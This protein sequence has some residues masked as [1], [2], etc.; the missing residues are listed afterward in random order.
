MRRRTSARAAVAAALLCTTRARR[1]SGKA[2][3]W[4]DGIA[5]ELE[6]WDRWLRTHGGE[7]QQ[8]FAFRLNASSP[9]YFQAKL[10]RH[11]TAH[12]THFRVL[13]VGSG[14]I[15]GSGYRITR[16]P[17]MTMELFATDPLTK[18]YEALLARHNIVP[19]VRAHHLE[20]EQLTERFN[21]NFFDMAFSVNA[22]DHA[23]NPME[24]MRQV[25]CRSECSPQRARARSSLHRVAPS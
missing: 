15:A 24:C 5:P 6:Y 2:N 9:F 20:G 14:P 17:G 7:Y 16:M 19:V 8:D 4:A 11:R 21:D 13:D 23:A 22:L 18:Q 25:R 3:Q 10:L 1:L 12:Q